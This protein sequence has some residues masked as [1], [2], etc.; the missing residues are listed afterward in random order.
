[1]HGIGRP[2]DAV[3]ELALWTSALAEGARAAG[4]SAFADAV[5]GG[6]LDIRFAYY[7]DLFRPSQ[8]QGASDLD[9]DDVEAGILAELLTEI[10]AGRLAEPLEEQ[11]RR[12]LEHAMAEAAPSGQAQGVGNLIRRS[13]NVAA[14]LFS[15]KP[16]RRGAQWVTPKLMVF[17][18]AQVARYL[19]RSEPDADG[20][21]LDARIRARIAAALGDGPTVVVAHSLGS[22]VAFEALGERSEAVELFV[23]IGSPLAMRTVVL[24]RLRPQ[25]PWTPHMVRQWL[26]F[27]DHDDIFTGRPDLAAD[28]GAN[29]AG[30]AAESS[31]VDSDGLWVHT[32]TKY[33]AKQDVARPVAQAFAPR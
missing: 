15:V 21:T 13:L 25:P 10:V 2:R 6:S 23:T 14:T 4:C 1:M 5:V 7:G 18:L 31:R 19:A 20:V 27:W 16:L 12:L 17:E 30:I 24:P 33:L 32:A 29:D 22:V 3:K 8:G 26:N 28:I 9:L 11:D